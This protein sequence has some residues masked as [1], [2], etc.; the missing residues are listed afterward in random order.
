MNRQ[1]SLL[2]N[3]LSW[4]DAD[5]SISEILTRTYLATLGLKKGIMAIV[6]GHLDGGIL[7]FLAGV[8][9]GSSRKS[10]MDSVKM[11]FG[12]KGGLLFAILNVIQLVD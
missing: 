11:S 1:T 6:L 5:I 4:F 7:F 2:D 3:G 9:G 10:A 12:K 8:I